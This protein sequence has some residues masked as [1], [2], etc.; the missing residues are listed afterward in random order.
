MDETKK[1]RASQNSELLAQI[2]LVSKAAIPLE[3]V[4]NGAYQRNMPKTSK[5]ILTK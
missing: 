4:V 5:D 1:G 3:P 2:W